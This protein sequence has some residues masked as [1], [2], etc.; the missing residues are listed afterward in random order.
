VSAVEAFDA[1]VVGGGP[2]GAT[3]ATELA[4]RGRSVLMLDR[5]H[6]IK[7]CGGAIPPQLMREFGIPESLLAARITSARM[8][9]P[10]DR[11]VDMPIDGGFVGMVKR[12][13][14]DEWLRQ[15]AEV[16]GALRRTGTVSGV[17][18][19][20]QGNAIVD[21]FPASAGGR[22]RV[23]TA[24]RARCVIGADG[25][26]STVARACI[27]GAPSGRCRRATSTPFRYTTRPP[28]N[29]TESVRAFTR[30][31]SRTSNL[32]LDRTTL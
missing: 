1:V 10:S 22:P 26:V 24:V 8:I 5:G 13:V 11:R 31:G 4:R 12:D 17:R 19:D 9:A 28:R 3:A 7:P 20:G 2:A 21:Y 16:A 25:A 6:R 29:E 32:P 14:F 23:A 30:A 15:R 27:P 18:R